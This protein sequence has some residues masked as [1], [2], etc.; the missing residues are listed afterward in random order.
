M[1]RHHKMQRQLAGTKGKTE[2]PLRGGKRLDVLK[3]RK[4][5]EVERSGDPRRIALALNR[6]KVKR[7]LKKELKV[8]QKDLDKAVTIAKK[9]NIKVTITNL[10][11]TKKRK[12]K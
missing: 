2:V 11:G 12:I 1:G 3:G 9:K 10:S 5:I 4:A 7:T 6:L 8:P